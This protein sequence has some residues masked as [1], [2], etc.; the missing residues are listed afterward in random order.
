MSEAFVGEL[1]QGCLDLR[2]TCFVTVLLDR[3]LC[4]L[5]YRQRTSGPF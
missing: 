3:N 2:R 4:K 5:G 1:R